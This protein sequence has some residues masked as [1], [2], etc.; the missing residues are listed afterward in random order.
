MSVNALCVSMNDSERGFHTSSLTNVSIGQKSFSHRWGIS[1]F[2]KII[3]WA[4][5]KHLESSTFSI[6]TK[7]C[8]IDWEISLY[9][10]GNAEDNVGYLSIFLVNKSYKSMKDDVCVEITFSV[11]DTE[12]GIALYKQLNPKT[13]DRTVSNWGCTKFIQTSTL[14]DRGLLLH[15]TIFLVAKVTL[16]G[17]D[18]IVGGNG[19]SMKDQDEAA[20]L[21]R[22]STDIESMLDT[23]RFSDCVIACGGQ[24]FPCHKF[25][26]SARSPVF[27]AMF[28]HDTKEQARNRVEIKDLDVK[29]VQ[30]MIDYIYSGQVTELESKAAGL[31]TAAEKYDLEELKQMCVTSLCNSIRDDNVL[32]M[33]V[34]VE[35]YD[36]P[37]LRKSALEFTALHKKEV[38]NQEDWRI[39]LENYP[40]IIAD[41]YEYDAKNM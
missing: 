33:L 13:L 28:S 29:V 14:K 9:P 36:L 32:D 25:I 21:C 20:S 16:V 17:D 2:T 6:I 4:S 26:L 18:L 7:K 39:K 37:E 22:L 3:S 24:E 30:D 31:I 10:N 1:N 8:K 34:L 5:G 35:T 12:G 15:D 40:G 23:G 11:L 38:V 27:D 19:S 41:M